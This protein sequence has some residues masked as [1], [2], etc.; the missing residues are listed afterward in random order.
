[1]SFED[2][3][4]HFKLEAEVFPEYTL[5]VSYRPNR[6]RGVR[7]KIE[8]KW[9]RMDSI[10]EGAFG[11]VWRELHCQS[12][13]T[14]D[15]RAVKI[16]EKQRMRAYNIDFKKELLALAKFSK[17]EVLKPY[18]GSAHLATRLMLTQ[19]SIDKRRYLSRFSAG[20]RPI[21]PYS[22][23]WSISETATW[24][25]IFRTFPLRRK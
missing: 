3:L 19:T 5:H 9:K 8:T 2:L 13:G 21:R 20:S 23:Q 18:Q 24:L 1:M 10:G 11:Q 6:A 17:D 16:I 15:I 7:E 4:D 14:P 22:L 12:D 25:G